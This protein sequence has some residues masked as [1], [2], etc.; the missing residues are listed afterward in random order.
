MSDSDKAIAIYEKSEENGQTNPIQ[1]AFK[2]EPMTANAV[3]PVEL[4]NAQSG[5]VSD[6]T[7]AWTAGT[8]LKGVTLEN[9]GAGTFGVK[10]GTVEIG[11]FK[12][13]TNGSYTFTPKAGIKGIDGG[14]NLIASFNKGDHV[15]NINLTGKLSNNITANED[16]VDS[17]YKVSADSAKGIDFGLIGKVEM[18][19]LSAIENGALQNVTLANVNSSGNNGLFIKGDVGDTITLGSV[20]ETSTTTQTDVGGNWT[21]GADRTGSTIDNDASVYTAWTNGAT[22]LYIDKDITVL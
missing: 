8:G 10:K 20:L 3:K 15:V 9:K 1:L 21:K 4:P 11:E 12:G 16:L 5:K 17:I 2:L 22:T 13:E 19:D 14:E 18:I 6:T 7:T